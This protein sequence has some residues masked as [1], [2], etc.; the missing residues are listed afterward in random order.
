MTINTFGEF[1]YQKAT[2]AINYLAR[3]EGGKID[4]LKLIKLIY[5][6]ERY[7]LR[8]HGR[9]IINDTYFAMKRGPVPSSVKDIVEMSGFLADEERDYAQK[10]ICPSPPYSVDSLAEV[11]TDLFSDSELDALD[12][13]YREF[14][15]AHQHQLVELTHE[16]PEWKQFETAIESGRTTREVMSYI[17]FFNNPDNLAE[18]KFMLSADILSVSRE[19]FEEEQAL[20]KLWQ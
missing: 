3:K 12:F 20:L 16:Y 4:K 6:A 13:A 10:F 15:D 19:V 14:G 5:F 18:D 2:Q 11:D 7:H 17:D 1:D 9:P 8:R